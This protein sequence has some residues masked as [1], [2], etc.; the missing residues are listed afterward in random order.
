MKPNAILLGWILWVAAGG[1]STAQT[2]G[3]SVTVI[4]AMRDVMWKGELGGNL[5]LDTLLPQ[6]H[7]YGLG[8]VAYLT[9]EILILDGKSYRSTVAADASIKTEETYDLQAPFFGYAHVPAW[10]EHPLP[11]SILTIRQLET[12][13]DQTI[14]AGNRPLMFRLVGDFVEMTIH[15]VNLPPGTMVQSPAAAHQGQ[16]TYQLP[17]EAGEVLGFFSTKHKTIFTHHDTWLH[18][19]FITQDRQKMGH[20]DHFL[21]PKGGVTLYLPVQ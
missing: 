1:C 2:T 20:V 9:G 10:R 15:I 21:L 13:L 8:P 11:D 3:T 5:R 7:L 16:Q 12:Y 4:G 19:H 18:M 14:P 17:H 6:A